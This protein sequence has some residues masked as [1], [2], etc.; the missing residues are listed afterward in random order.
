M[1]PKPI[2]IL[3]AMVLACKGYSQNAGADPK[4]IEWL[5]GSWMG[6]YNN[7]PFFE[8]W[9]KVNDSVFVNFKIEIEGQILY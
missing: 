4:Q 7:A 6:M 1:R 8:A 9:R 3:L 5:Q 2:L